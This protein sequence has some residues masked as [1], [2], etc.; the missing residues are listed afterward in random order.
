[1]R[2]SL[3]TV[4]MQ[5]IMSGENEKRTSLWDFKKNDK[6]ISGEGHSLLNARLARC[7][8]RWEYLFF[9]SEYSS[10]DQIS[11]VNPIITKAYSCDGELVAP[12]WI[13]SEL[14]HEL[15]LVD[16]GSRI[17]M[18]TKQ[19]LRTKEGYIIRFKLIVSLIVRDW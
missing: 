10:S 4:V 17:T 13:G 14:Q 8:E 3:V 11:P 15:I 19:M 5:K 7:I 1:M 12:L 16:T 2:S 6:T 18:W 9:L